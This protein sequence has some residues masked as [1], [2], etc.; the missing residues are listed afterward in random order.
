[1]RLKNVF[2]S[3]LFTVILAG[4]IVA[5]DGS[6]E[7]QNLPF[8][9]YG[10]GPIEVRIFSDYFCPPCR[11][12]EPVVEPILKDLL[13]KNVIRLTVIDTPFHPHTLLYARYFLYALK[14]NGGVDH[15]FRVRNILFDASTDKTVTTQ[16]R[17]ETIFK[18]KGIPYAAFDTKPAFDRYNTLIKEDNIKAT[19]TCVII[20]SGQM[21]TF[22]GGPDIISALKSLQ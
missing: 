1:M 7:E 13:E 21:K 8:P 16:E 12:V 4:L 2:V 14:E 10:S 19:P 15:A 3:G 5:A 9:S 11:A 17:I 22:V 20:K 6:A 18:E